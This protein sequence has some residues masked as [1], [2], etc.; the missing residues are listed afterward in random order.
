V[1]VEVVPVDPDAG[2]TFADHRAA[3]AMM[4]RALAG[5]DTLSALDRLRGLY[6][7]LP[8]GTARR[9]VL[10]ARLAIL[11]DD[12]PERVAPAAPAP[13]VAPIAPKAPPKAGALS[14]LALDAAARLLMEAGADDDAPPPL[15]TPKAAPPVADLFAALAAA[16]ED[17]ADE[18]SLNSAALEGAFDAPTPQDATDALPEPNG[19]DAQEV[20]DT[21][22]TA[23]GGP[24]TAADLGQ[25]GPASPAQ[26]KAKPRKAKSIAF[27]P[28]ALAAL[29]EPEDAA[30]FVPV[31]PKAM[32][33]AVSAL[34][35]LAD[36]TPAP[37]AAFDLNAAFAAF[38]DSDDAPLAPPDDLVLTDALSAM[39][40]ADPA[41]LL[42]P[43]PP[44]RKTPR[45]ATAEADI[46][47][48]LS[49][50]IG[51][52]DTPVA[53]AMA[54]ADVSELL[55][56]IE[57]ATLDTGDATPPTKPKRAKPTDLSDVSAAFA[58]LG[59]TDTD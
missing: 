54:E 35:A 29:T 6:A 37:R 14:T 8:N 30:G 41:A 18:S 32:A 21:A 40:A 49:A 10:A 52:G 17:D 20:S 22:Q 26:P 25:E 46:A 15:R 5:L 19:E 2:V 44:R 13:V 4:L 59:S 16:D 3:S 23:M 1:T 47:A 34:D 39:D 7:S 12:V 48:S 33:T 53:P 28:A 43:K 58:A 50:L 56:L 36:D 11:R 38:G 9:A 24:E 27:D 57:P 45:A 31:P 42:R 51:E 55:N